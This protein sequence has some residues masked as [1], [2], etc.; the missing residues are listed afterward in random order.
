MEK[1]AKEEGGSPLSPLE[2]TRR[3]MNLPVFA[4]AKCWERGELRAGQEMAGSGQ[5]Q[6]G[7]RKSHGP[8]S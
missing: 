6:G 2:D 1:E 7:G 3:E 5:G 4:A 8:W